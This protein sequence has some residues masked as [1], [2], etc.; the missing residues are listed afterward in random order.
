MLKAYCRW[1]MVAPLVAVGVVLVSQAA[2]AQTPPPGGGTGSY[3]TACT[4]LSAFFTFFYAAPFKVGVGVAL[5][6]AL[7]GNALDQG[8]FGQMASIFLRI[9]LIV[10]GI[11][12]VIS[13][14]GI[15]AASC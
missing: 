10:L 14:L 6:A 12:G 7:I 13:Y 5:I 4:G 15:G 1:S 11:A 9:I 2:G 3:S 8:Q